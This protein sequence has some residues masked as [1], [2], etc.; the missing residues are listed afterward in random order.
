MQMSAVD[1]RITAL[2]QTSHI[3]AVT[4]GQ[5]QCLEPQ[6]GGGWQQQWEAI[7]QPIAKWKPGRSVRRTYQSGT[8]H[9]MAMETAAIREAVQEPMRDSGPM[10][11][12]SRRLV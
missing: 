5:N 6:C 3:W 8:W 11:A 1:L 2:Q 9:R 4:R 7:Q 12:A 10:A